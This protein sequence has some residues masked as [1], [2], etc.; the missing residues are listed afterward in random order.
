MA[1]LTLAI[2]E[3]Q[4]ELYKDGF[5]GKCHLGRKSEGV[6][7][8]DLV[9]RV[10]NPMVVALDGPWGS[11]KSFF[12][13]CWVGEHTKTY[14]ESATTVYF[15]AFKDDFLDDPLISIVAALSERL[16]VDEETDP[17][18]STVAKGLEHLKRYAPVL[19]RGVLRAGINKLSANA[20][21][22][23]EDAAE[24]LQDDAINVFST[25]AIKATNEFWQADQSKRAA[26]AG[27]EASLAEI[28]TPKKKMIIVVDELDR[29]RPDY[30][31]SVLETIKHFFQVPNV[32][33]I[34]GVN[35]AEL[36]NSVR[37]RYGAATA[38]EKYLQKFV[39]VTMPIKVP[40]G[41][42]A[43][44][45]KHFDHVCNRLGIYDNYQHAYL[46]SY[47]AIITH[48][49]A[50]SLRDVE[51]IATL[52]M[53][54][55]HPGLSGQQGGHFFAGLA[56]LKVI[57]PDVFQALKGNAP[58]RN[59]VLNIFDF[60]ESSSGSDI[61]PEALVLWQAA[62]K[63]FQNSPDNRQAYASV[64]AG[65]SEQLP[66]KAIIEINANRDMRTIIENCLDAFQ[67]P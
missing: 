35:L 19:A 22:G 1:D 54:S 58:P 11:G 53:V 31:L 13:K 28:A 64:T 45:L 61:F 57:A 62:L 3:T 2:P 42:R 66:T 16:A 48:H 29:C 49:A 30:A 37:A 52:A 17:V 12:L 41:S 25:E 32:H 65:N 34:L 33:F 6:Q 55:P 44:Q 50:L 67:L 15:D 21:D 27:F 51:R 59:A 26:M 8:S 43:L 47:L 63:T 20:L 60:D 56:I 18:S 46:R 38:A 24:T 23:I 5:D 7:L 4:F 9:Q 10:D 14:N 36:A 40:R 39:T